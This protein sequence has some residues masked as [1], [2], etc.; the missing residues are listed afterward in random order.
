MWWSALD[1]GYRAGRNTSHK[2]REAR[3]FRKEPA[4]TKA[5][6]LS[7][8]SFRATRSSARRTAEESRDL[9]FPAN[10]K[11]IPVALLL[12]ALC[13]CKV[14]PN[15]SRPTLSVPDQYR[16]AP[17]LTTQQPSSEQFA[18]MKWWAVFQDETL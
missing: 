9:F 18:Q 4:M 16:N 10:M 12:L 2:K 17:D 6:Y 7:R 8:L 5:A 11:I 15:Y 14:G 1:Y 13:A 3:R